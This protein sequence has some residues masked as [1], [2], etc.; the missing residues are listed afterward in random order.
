MSAIVKSVDRIASK[1][2]AQIPVLV[3]SKILFD[4]KINN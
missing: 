4:N 3:E 2:S 1:V